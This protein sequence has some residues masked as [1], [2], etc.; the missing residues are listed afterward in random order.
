MWPDMVVMVTPLVYF[1]SGFIQIIKPVLVQTRVSKPPIET[2]HKGIHFKKLKSSTQKEYMRQLT[3]IKAVFGHMP[4]HE[5][6]AGDVSD[7][8][9]HLATERATSRGPAYV[10]ANR[11]KACMQKL[12]AYAVTKKKMKTNP[13]R[14][15]PDFEEEARD[16]YIEDWEYNAIYEHASSLCRAAME[17][18]YLCMARIGDVVSLKEQDLW[19]EGIYIRQAKTNKQ[20]IKQW[21]DRLRDAV[22]MCRALPLKKGMSTIFLFHKPDGS[23]YQKRSIQR[24]YKAAKEKA[25]ITDCTFQDIKAKAIS[26]FDGTISEKQHAAGHTSVKQTLAYDRKVR[27]VKPTR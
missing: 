10:T 3:D 2:F 25:K 13:C 5:I 14:E 21:S 24:H 18:S 1:V 27:V 9:E 26:D 6:D 22:A 11:Y 20:Q 7:F 15:V 12:C 17:I 16:R 23:R 4:P 8:M 19:E